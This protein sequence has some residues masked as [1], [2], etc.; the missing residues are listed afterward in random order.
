MVVLITL[1]NHLTQRPYNLL[2]PGVRGPFQRASHMT[3][4]VAGREG[5]HTEE[6]H[7]KRGMTITTVMKSNR[8]LKN[9]AGATCNPSPHV[10]WFILARLGSLTHAHLAS[11]GCFFFFLAVAGFINPQGEGTDYSRSMI[12][13]K[14]RTGFQGGDGAV[15]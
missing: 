6:T 15:Q 3:L 12:E 2:Q 9:R 1:G 4:T 11:V 14:T 7:I 5:G 13:I 8:R 10:A